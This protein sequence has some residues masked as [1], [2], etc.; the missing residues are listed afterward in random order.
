MK[1]KILRLTMLC[2]LICV[3]S[4]TSVFAQSQN[5]EYKEMLKKM[6]ELSGANSASDAML[7]QLQ[8]FFKRSDSQTGDSIFADLQKTWKDKIEG[9]MIDIYAPIYQR[10]LTLTDL[11]DVIA[12]YES[13]VGKKLG[14]AAPAIIKEAF[15][16][17]Q[18]LGMELASSIISKFSKPIVKE[19]CVE[20]KR[21]G[22]TDQQMFDEGYILPKDSVQVSPIP[23]AREMGNQP[24]LYAIEQ[25]KNDT[26]VTF[27]NPIYF[28]SQW[29]TYGAGFK[30]IDKDSGDEY[31]VR[32]YDGGIPFDRLLIVQGFNRKNILVSLLF[33][34][35][36]KNVK[37]I[38][39]IETPN[40]K[41]LV[42]SND[43]GKRTAIYNIKITDYLKSSKA[44][45]KV[46]Y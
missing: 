20:V 24:M 17:M 44:E 31:V 22:K 13:P 11:K 9:E 38:D 15:P 6:L 16:K 7:E 39:I 8:S 40:E 1:N 18:Q 30:I 23:Y 34:K 26:K 46:Y 4:I 43:D 32:G 21:N 2:M 28:D 33:P 14:N 41:D 45:K 5:A 27:S 25:R 12:F 29:V 3:A 10:H 19:T 36:N 42:P 37:N 35:L